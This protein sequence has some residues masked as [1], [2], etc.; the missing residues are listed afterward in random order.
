MTPISTQQ[1]RICEFV[2]RYRERNRLSPTYAEIGEQLGVTKQAV[3]YQVRQLES[4]GYLAKPRDARSLMVTDAWRRYR[5]HVLDRETNP[6]VAVALDEQPELFAGFDESD[7][8]TLY[9]TRGV[10][11][12]LTREGVE[13]A[14]V[15]IN[16]NR[17][18][19]QQV[20][21][22]LENAGVRDELIAHIDELWQRVT[23]TPR[24]RRRTG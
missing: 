11:G 23:V 22:L 16:E 5:R 24:K 15:R 13:Q 17:D 21:Q 1:E 8:E 3:Q 19:R 7:W 10:G 6:Q 18:R 20:A 12:A 4:A 9:S 2:D 14:A